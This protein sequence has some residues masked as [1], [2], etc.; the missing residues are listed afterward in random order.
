MALQGLLG[1]R[2]CPPRQR[3]H[4]AARAR[5][6]GQLRSR[7]DGLPPSHLVPMAGDSHTG[8]GTRLSGVGRTRNGCSRRRSLCWQ[9]SALCRGSRQESHG[10]TVSAGSGKPG[11]R[12]AGW[13]WDFQTPPEVFVLCRAE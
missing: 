11:C 13:P 4:G 8:C 7:G 1:T 12:G 6:R 3:G 9:A 10:H 2:H 5:G